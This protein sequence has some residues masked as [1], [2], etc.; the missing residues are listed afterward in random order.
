MA[1]G[2]VTVGGTIADRKTA[3]SVIYSLLR[4]VISVACVVLGCMILVFAAASLHV[5][6][7]EEQTGGV[8]GET[9]EETRGEL[10]RNPDTGFVVWLEDDAE[11]LSEEERIALGGQMQ[12]VTEFGNAVFKSVSRNGLGTDGYAK[13]FYTSL[14]EGESGMVFLIDTDNSGLGIYSEGT[15]HR[16]VREEGAREI[17]DNTYVYALR[18]EYYTCG[19]RAFEQAEEL[20]G[21][22]YSMRSMKYICNALLA[23]TVALLINYALVNFLS[24]AR[25][26]E[27]DEMLAHALK[28]FSNT[29]PLVCFLY[30]DK[31]D[32][33]SFHTSGIVPE[34]IKYGRHKR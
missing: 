10:Y 23:L 12:A 21:N 30:Q 32:P 8:Q 14:F 19:S 5:A 16:I 4:F 9:G 34:Y 28:Y 11:L 25:R 3:D 1:A 26:T 13:Y 18:G 15:V 17:T 29:D 2:R 24:K 7:A 27:E 33:G 31:A 20:L 22:W 6:A